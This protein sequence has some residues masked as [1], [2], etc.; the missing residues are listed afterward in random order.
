MVTGIEKFREYFVAHE[1]QYAIIGGTACDLLF[2]AAGLNFTTFLE[3]VV[4]THEKSSCPSV[5][6][7]Q[8]GEGSSV[9]KAPPLRGGFS[10]QQVLWQDALSPGDTLQ[11]SVAFEA[12]GIAA[13]AVVLDDREKRWRSPVSL[14]VQCIVAGVTI[15]A[16]EQDCEAFWPIVIPEALLSIQYNKPSERLR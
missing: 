16:D 2:N 15:T 11:K 8:L 14:A 9:C 7:T 5:H 10:N 6:A 13:E 1:D 4:Y 12:V 3:I